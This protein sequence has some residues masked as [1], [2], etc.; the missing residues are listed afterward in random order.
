MNLEQPALTSLPFSIP[1]SILLVLTYLMCPA[2]STPNASKANIYENLGFAFKALCM[3]HQWIPVGNYILQKRSWFHQ[4]YLEK[5]SRYKF[6]W[7]YRYWIIHEYK[8]NN[9]LLMP[10]LL[11]ASNATKCSVT[12]VEMPLIVQ[13][14]EPWKY[15]P[16]WPFTS[17]SPW[18]VIILINIYIC[19]CIYYI[20]IYIWIYVL[21][22]IY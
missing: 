8:T 2:F 22:I 9:V 7:C 1:V 13:R 17:K 16:C 4:L 6:P 5:R 14:T 10:T 12:M 11:S 19:V 3:F 21:Y 15:Y 20:Y 18:N